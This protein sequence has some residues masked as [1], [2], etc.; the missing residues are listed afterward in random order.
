MI[1]LVVKPSMMDGQNSI[2]SGFANAFGRAGKGPHN[3]TLALPA[4]GRGWA[5]YLTSHG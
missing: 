4:L 1:E 3:P 5:N 2:E